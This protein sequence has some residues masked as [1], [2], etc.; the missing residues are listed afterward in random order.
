MW[1]IY[2]SKS[3]MGKPVKK[4]SDTELIWYLSF[5]NYLYTNYEN[6]DRMFVYLVSITLF[7]NFCE[8]ILLIKQVLIIIYS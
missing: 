2:S 3:E 4:T 8:L 1:K 7:K 6:A 5:K